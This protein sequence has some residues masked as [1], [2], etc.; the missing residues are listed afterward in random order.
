MVSGTIPRSVLRHEGGFA[1]CRKHHA[2]SRSTLLEI[3]CAKPSICECGMSAV[4]CMQ[5]M[6]PSCGSPPV[7][8]ASNSPTWC[9]LARFS[10]LKEGFLQ[11]CSWTD[12]C[13][14]AGCAGKCVANEGLT[15]SW[16]VLL[17]RAAGEDSYDACPMFAFWI[18]QWYTIYEGNSFRR[19][20]SAKVRPVMLQ[21]SA[22]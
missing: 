13:K 9:C 17:D 21:L 8:P 1:C 11:A 4:L 12:A 6:S 14:V 3:S 16:D 22:K 10:L 19:L 5:R 7:A 18:N 20:Q 15:S 2:G